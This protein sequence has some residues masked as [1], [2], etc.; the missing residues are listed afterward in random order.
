MATKSRR[1]E[2][3]EE[4]D[5]PRKKKRKKSNAPLFIGLGVGAGV[6]LVVIIVLVVVIAINAGGGNQPKK[7]QGD[8]FA[9][10]KE[11]PPPPPP[12]K[13]NFDKVEIGEKPRPA[14]SIRARVD[15]SERLNELK[16]IG[17]LY[18]QYVVNFN[19][20]PATVQDFTEYIKRDAPGIKKAIDEKYYIIVPKVTAGSGIV[21]YEFDPDTN[22]R[23]GITLMGGTAHD[24]MTTQELVAALKAQGSG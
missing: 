19:K 12:V 22:S 18:Q 24:D 13:P 14:N 17:S 6:L 23:H 9:G 8:P 10:F 20:P 7:P 4:D 5:R 3:D 11:P 16:Q 21:A 1:R 2:D 15:R